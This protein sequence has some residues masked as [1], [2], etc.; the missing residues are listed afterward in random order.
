MIP[1]PRSPA[2]DRSHL[3]S[4][5]RSLWDRHRETLEDLLEVALDEELPV[6]EGDLAALLHHLHG[7]IVRTGLATLHH[8]DPTRPELFNPNAR[9]WSFA[10]SNADTYYLSATV[11][12]AYDYRVFG[13]LGSATHVTFGM[14]AGVGDQDRAI[15]IRAEDIEVGPGGAFELHFSREPHGRNHFP[16]LAGAQS[17]ACYQVFEDW[18]TSTP[19]EISIERTGPSAPARGPGFD[20]MATRFERYLTSLREDFEIWTVVVPAV[21]IDPIPDNAFMEALQPPAFFAGAWVMPI[22]WRLAEHE[23]L[24]MELSLPDDCAYSG[25]TMTNRWGQMID[26]DRRQT[27][28][29]RKQ[30][31][32]GDDGTLRVLLSARDHG[33]RNW[34]DASGYD[35]GIVAWR[36]TQPKAPPDP[37]L[38]VVAGDEL[39]AVVAGMDRV[40]PEERAAALDLRRRHFARLSG[41]C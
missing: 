25:L 1:D 24:L 7:H 2:K 9:P 37:V 35:Q 12:D 34:L 6:G 5:I 14:Y 3:R 41:G 29:N 15:K 30:A 23:A 8:G 10:H 17:F 27:S 26:F 21:T 39:R 11:S 28:L 13:K 16:R 36:T 22:K 31:T 40:T 20:D 32:V 18:T 33:V 19:C 4:T 38:R